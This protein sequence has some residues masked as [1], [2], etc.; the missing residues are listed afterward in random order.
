[1]PQFINLLT[2]GA[3]AAMAVASP[4]AQ[5]ATA[6]TSSLEERASCTFSGSKGAASAMASKQKCSTIVLSNVAV[7]AGVKL[8]LSKLND[9]TQVIFEGTTTW[10]YKEWEGP[11]LDI[12]GKDITVTGASGAKLNPDGARWWDGKG[13]NGGKTK[14]KFFAAHK[15]TGKSQINN[16]YIENTPVQ[17]VSINGCKGLTINKMTIDNRAGDS[18]GGHNTDG[19]D[20][21]SSSN[22]V[23][24]GATVYNQDD[25]VAVNSGTDITFSGGYCSGGHGLSIGSV[26][27]RSDNTVDNVTFKDSTVTKSDNGIR[28]K[29]KSGTTGIIKG[30]T[31]SGITLSSI[32]KYGILIEQNYDGGDLHGSPTGGLPINN[33]VLSNI[34]GSN[35]VSSSGHDVAIVCAS[36]A[37]NNWTWNKVSVSGGKTYGSCKNVPSVASC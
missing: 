30:V 12:G 28:V 37:C 8:D 14:P 16:L 11:L 20:I 1:M 7:P 6:A 5:P 3:L 15:L 36:G 17:A 4:V 23:I 13:G 29:A 32:K 9:G 24:N 33:L 18:K 2:V 21:G 34:S 10:G 19:F 27:G 26:G 25:C 22:V 31:Y 35:A